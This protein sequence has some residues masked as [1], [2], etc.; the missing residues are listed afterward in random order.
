MD[1]ETHS[2]HYNSRFAIGRRLKYWRQRENLSIATAAI[3]LGVCTSTW[4]HWETGEHLPSGDLLLAIED[5]TRMPLHVLF[6][7]YFDVC[8][9]LT[10]AAPPPNSPCCH[11]DAT[12]RIPTGT[13]PFPTERLDPGAQPGAQS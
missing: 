8:P 11:C 7:P 5:L 9:H 4:G 3:E 1:P 6:C 13:F 2:H 10:G 12:P